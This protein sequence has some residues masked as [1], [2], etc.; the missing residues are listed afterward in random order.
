MERAAANAEPGNLGTPSPVQVLSG[1]WQIV[2]DPENR[3]RDECWCDAARPDALPAPVPGIIQQVFPTGHGVFWY[4]IQFTPVVSAAA[5]ERILLRFGAVD[6]LA[7]VWLNG[8]YMGG[9]EGGETPFD[10][11]ATEALEPSRRNLLA[12]RVL[13]PTRD[14]ID[15][16]R[17]DETPHRNKRCHDEFTPGSGF[18]TGGIILPV[19][20]E[21]VP[22]LR[23][24]DV[25]ARPECAT[26]KIHLTV[27]LR[28]DSGK[29]LS[30][31]LRASAAPAAEG[32]TLASVTAELRAPSGACARDLVLEL[33]TRTQYA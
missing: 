12:V 20:L 10:L 17:L 13:N 6:Y 14:P 5:H 19:S 11:D 33:G 32:R 23:I 30:A 29:P 21:V 24:A 18:N 9:H 4:Y 31:R 28:N 27:T 26:G 16:I 25:F 7:D 1:S 22:A 15:G 8:R 3:G 2:A